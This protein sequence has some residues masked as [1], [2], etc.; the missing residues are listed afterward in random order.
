MP[1]ATAWVRVDASSFARIRFVC[2]RTVSVERPRSFATRVGLHAVGQHL[3]DLALAR[4][5]RAVALLEHDR[6]GQPRVDVELA[7]AGG[8]DRADQVGGGGVLA[9]VA[10]HAGLQRLAQQARPAVG[11]ED[12]DRRAQRLRQPLHQLAHVR[13]GSPRVHD[14][15]VE[16]AVTAVGDG[17]FEVLRVAH[18]RVRPGRFEQRPHAL[19]HHRMLVDDEAGGGGLLASGHV[20]SIP[21]TPMASPPRRTRVP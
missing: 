4:A 14:H 2:V 17:A 19:A 13:A 9:H 6:R 11:G 15:H 21:K 5:Q 7:A 20:P 18:R 10:L 3:E 12:D 16:L 1:I 8:L